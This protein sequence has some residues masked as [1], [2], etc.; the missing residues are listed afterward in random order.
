MSR[1][2]DLMR[3]LCPDGV[4]FKGI[5]TFAECLSGATPKTDV[6]D[7]WESGTIPWMSSGEVNNRVIKSV[8]ATITQQGYDSC[9]TKMVPQN[10]VVVALAGQGKTRGMVAIT[11]IPLCTNQSLCAIVTDETVDGDFLYHF[12]RSQYQQLRSVSSGDGMRGGLNLAMIRAYRIPVPPLKVQREIVSILDRF[13]ELEA[14]L[15]NELKAELEAR[16]KQYAFYRDALLTFAERER[17]RE[18]EPGGRPWVKLG[19]LS[20][21]TGYRRK[22]SPKAEWGVSITGRFTPTTAHLLAKPSRSCLPSWRGGSRW[23]NRGISSLRPQVK[24]MKP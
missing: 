4:E 16:R 11:R 3:E 10:T 12:L 22:T 6:A 15:E 13:T 14:E 24:M 7:Y 18:R 2:D 21:A 5:G 8:K 17:E 20:E 23:P 1:I 9:S 19:H